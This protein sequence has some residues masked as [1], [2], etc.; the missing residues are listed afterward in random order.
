VGGGRK[1]V[2]S[3]VG[4]FTKGGGLGASEGE[5]WDDGR[6]WG[7]RDP[8]EEESDGD[9][10]FHRVER[11]KFGRVVQGAGHTRRWLTMGREEKRWG[12]KKTG[13]KLEE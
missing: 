4:G 2:Y 13:L 7:K 3:W 6:R 9:V 8:A 10:N 11:R 1:E 5:P 12:Q